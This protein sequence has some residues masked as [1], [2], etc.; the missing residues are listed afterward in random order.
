MSCW[1]CKESFPNQK[2]LKNHVATIHC[3]LTVV[4]PFCDR[5]EQRFKRVSDLKVHARKFHE[6]QVQKLPPGIFSENN[7]FWSSIHPSDYRQLIKPS[8]RSSE[9]A[10]QMRTLILD[11]AK[12]MGSKASRSRDD[13]L[14]GWK[15]P[16]TFT[17]VIEDEEFDYFDQEEEPKLIYVSLIPGSIFVD[18]EKGNDKFRLVILDSIFR[19]NNSIR[20]LSRRMGG[21]PSTALPFGSLDAKEDTQAAHKLQL[22]QFIGIKE[23]FVEKV[24]R[25]QIIMKRVLSSPPPTSSIKKSR[26][27]TDSEKTLSGQSGIPKDRSPEPAQQAQE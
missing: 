15:E 19:D 20:S 6:Q 12:L 11:W 21:L 25:K 13:F 10:I 22:C 9:Q 23:E 2:L 7:G 18:V 14:H 17:L 5:T 24:L 4:C 27:S 1:H 26:A 8:A 16:E 3:G